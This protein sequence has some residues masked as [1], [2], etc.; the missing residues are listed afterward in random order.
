MLR[1]ER[2]NDYYRGRRADQADLKKRMC[3]EVGYPA[4]IRV[5]QCSE[6]ISRDPNLWAYT[7]GVTL[8]FNQREKPTNNAFIK[9]FNGKFRV[10][11]PNQH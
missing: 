1:A 2:V 11:C 3:I 10:E 8:D 5:D 6:F 9:S 7:R 4:L